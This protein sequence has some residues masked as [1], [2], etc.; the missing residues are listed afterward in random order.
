MS[1]FSRLSGIVAGNLNAL[2]DRVESPV[3]ISAQI[4]REMEDGLVEAKRY[5]VAAIAAERRL[6][7]ELE[8]QRLE[9]QRWKTRARE[10]LAAGREDLARQAL[11]R[12]QE[13]E[14]IAAGLETQ[15]ATA[16]R[17]REDLK[18]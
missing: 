6:A 15:A 4:L 17:M 5:A 2:L 10:A 1:L 16:R 14:E 9:A 18:T 8:Q 12:K 7:R 13:H 11:A 3:V